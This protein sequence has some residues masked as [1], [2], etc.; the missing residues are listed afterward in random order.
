MLAEYS[1]FGW[2][3][4][5]RYKNICMYHITLHF[6]AQT[7]G[8]NTY[9]H[10]KTHTHAH[11]RMRITTHAEYL[12]S[13]STYMCRLTTRFCVYVSFIHKNTRFTHCQNLIAKQYIYH[14]GSAILFTIQV[15]EYRDEEEI[16]RKETKH[17][18]KKKIENLTRV[19][20]FGREKE[21][22]KVPSVV[23]LYYKWNNKNTT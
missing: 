18:I 3:L 20:S 22:K 19:L 15:K 16:K 1:P 5:Q 17:R 7:T 13:V 12:V 14:T 6:S 23:R 2:L 10:K 4:C 11:H 9:K 8:I 21:I